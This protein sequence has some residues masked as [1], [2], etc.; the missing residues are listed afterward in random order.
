MR[1]PVLDGWG[2]AR[3]LAARGVKIPVLVMTAAQDGFR[4]ARE[5]HATGY[6]GKPFDIDALIYEI[7]RCLEN[8][9]SIVS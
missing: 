9:D 6:I 2:V 8:P 4:W 5:I 7:Q 3:E 1:M